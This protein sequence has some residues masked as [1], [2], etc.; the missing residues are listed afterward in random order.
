MKVKTFIP[1]EYIQDVIEMSRDVFSEKEELEFLKSC[2]FYLQE[3]FNS[4]QAIE[5]SMVDYL[6]DM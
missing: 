2:L 5:M 1:A 3:G 6:V 4:Q